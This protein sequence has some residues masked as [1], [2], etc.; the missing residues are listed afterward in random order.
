LEQTLQQLVQAVQGIYTLMGGGGGGIGAYRSTIVPQA[1]AVNLPNNVVTLVA[2]LVLPVGDWDV[3]GDVYIFST[4]GVRGVGGMISPNLGAPPT[5]PE[6]DVSISV[7]DPSGGS[8]L[9]SMRMG[10]VPARF[11]LSAPGLA[12]L[13]AIAVLSS[14]TASA[15]GRISARRMG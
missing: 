8:S 7:I 3:W 4:A 12:R 11:N 1:S 9:D 10:V 13:Q 14:G 5:D 2:T 15:Y 6:D